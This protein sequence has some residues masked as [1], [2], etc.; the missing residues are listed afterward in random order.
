[1][2]DG[3]SAKR[4]AQAVFQ[5]AAEQ[6]LF[7]HMRADLERISAAAQDET[8][9]AV[10]DSPRVPF[11]VKEELARGQ[12]S[13]LHPI[14]LNL[15]LLLI[16]KRRLGLAPELAREFAALVDEAQGIAHAEVTTA[17]PLSE[18]EQQ[19]VAQRLSALTGKQIVLRAK[20]DPDI[21][22]GLIAKIGDQLID[23]SARTRLVQLRRT[24]VGQ[25]R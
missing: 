9:A 6:G 7:A 1:M 20:V 19:Q 14:A 16:S 11:D 5:I 8:L 15:A 2:A 12:F 25:A 24:L 18:A 13:D 17:V 3:V 10:M 22:G 21:L 23:G 4:Y